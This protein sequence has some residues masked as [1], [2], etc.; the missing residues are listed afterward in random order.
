[1][2]CK[3]KQVLTIVRKNIFQHCITSYLVV[4]LKDSHDDHIK[5]LYQVFS[6]SISCELYLDI[7]LLTTYFGLLA[8]IL[9]KIISYHM[10]SNLQCMFLIIPH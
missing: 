10:F 2:L 4:L 5:E 8:I 9:R 7:D 3:K 1:M 6:V